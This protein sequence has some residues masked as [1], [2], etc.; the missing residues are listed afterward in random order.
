MVRV[1]VWARVRVRAKVRVW[2][3]YGS[4]LGLGFS[5]RGRVKGWPNI[6]KFTAPK[7]AIPIYWRENVS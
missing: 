6:Y 2:L 5:L 7:E 1:R 3:E 4:G